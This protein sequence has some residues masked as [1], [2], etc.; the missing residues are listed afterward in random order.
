MRVINAKQDTIW[1]MVRHV[2]HANTQLNLHSKQQLLELL[3][4]PRKKTIIKL[5]F[6]NCV[7]NGTN[8]FRLPVTI[9]VV[10]STMDCIAFYN[11]GEE[12]VGCTA[13]EASQ[14][15]QIEPDNHPPVLKTA[16]G[17]KILFN[18]GLSTLDSTKN[19]IKYILKKSLTIE[20]QLPTD[21]E[22]TTKDA[23]PS[24][25][26]RKYYLSKQL[27]IPSYTSYTTKFNT[28]I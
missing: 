16:I 22:K 14:N 6:A 28:D 23:T 2:A 8:R 20:D 11:V 7:S 13:L 25:V 9:K 15:M 21:L 5:Y 17:K 18:I 3:F 19:P 12:L 1:L 4:F 24:K 10:S 27:T 26:S